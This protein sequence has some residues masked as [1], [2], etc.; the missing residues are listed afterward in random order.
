MADDKKTT[1]QRSELADAVRDILKEVL[2]AAVGAGLE[3]ARQTA[4]AKAVA[5]APP[6]KDLSD[7]TECRQKRSAC[8]G[9]HRKL[10][11]LPEDQ[12]YAQWFQGL[13]VNGV[14]YLSDRPG[15]QITI[16][17]DLNAE[18]MI[19]QFVRNEK[20]LKHG[21]QRGRF[22]GAVGNPKALGPNDF[23]R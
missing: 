13:R 4:D 14:L 12:E 21:R 1:G 5:G 7:C 17:A 15:H 16:P 2:P 19:E 22:S 18:H 8:G 9:R 3:A 20:E 10:C 11:V 6:I 23:F